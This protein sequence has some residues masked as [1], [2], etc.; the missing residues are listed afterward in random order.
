MTPEPSRP[1]QEAASLVETLF[2]ILLLTILAL[3]GGAYLYHAKAQIA[4]QRNRRAI[5]ET[6]NGRLEAIRALHYDRA[7]PQTTLPDYNVYYLSRQGT[8]WVH[9]TTDPLETAVVNGLTLS[10]SSTV[11]FQD[12]DSG[13]PSYDYLKLTARAAYRLGSD[14]RLTLESYYAPAKL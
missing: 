13:L 11:Q 14:D 10:L 12:L 7:K 1:K 6:V 3:T 4:Q 5:L 8:N 2:A 9:S